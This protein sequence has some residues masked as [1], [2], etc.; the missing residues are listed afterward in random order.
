MNNFAKNQ[1]FSSED[2]ACNETLEAPTEPSSFST[3]Q[4]LMEIWNRFLPIKNL[5]DMLNF[6]NENVSK[7]NE[8]DEIRNFKR[9]T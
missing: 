1:I 8:L 3:K 5:D 6:T 2:Q 9:S 4:N 7:A